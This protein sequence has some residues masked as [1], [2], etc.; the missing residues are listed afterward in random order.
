LLGG[1]SLTF[2][3][4]MTMTDIYNDLEKLDDLRK[5]GVITEEEFQIKKKALLR[6]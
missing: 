2:K 5:K 1:G 3:K 6:L 4:E